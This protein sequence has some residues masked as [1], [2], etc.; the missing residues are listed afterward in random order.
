MTTR[1]KDST[2]YPIVFLMVDSADHQTG[3]TGLTP[4]LTASKN[5]GAF[6]AVSGA[7]SELSSGWYSWAGHATDRNTLGPLAIHVTGTGADVVDFTVDITTQDAFAAAGGGATAQQVWEYATRALTDKAGFSL[8]VA[9]PTAS[10]IATAVWGATTRTL[11]SFG[12]LISDIWANATRSLTEKTGFSLA[13]PPPTASDIATAV[14][15]AGTR[16]LT[17]FG[18]LVADIW[19]YVTRTITSGGITAQQVW[20]YATRALTDKAGF[21]L[22]GDYDAAKTAASAANLATVDT[23]ADAIKEKTDSLTFTTPNKVDA[24]ATVST[25]GIATSAEVAAVNAN[26]LALTGTT[27]S[28]TSTPPAATQLADADVPRD[29]WISYAVT[30]TPLGHVTGDLYRL[31]VRPF[32][33]L[34]TANVNQTITPAGEVFTLAFQMPASIGKYYVGVERK[35]VSGLTTQYTT[36]FWA[37]WSAIDDPVHPTHWA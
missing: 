4:T 15:A 25:A 13:T 17:S 3:K 6:G 9:P 2:A 12:T 23:V 36:L 5:G 1:L 33:A 7:V 27:V 8:S 20:E 22:H 28:Q 32:S 35:R 34:E 21:A 10:D 19:S 30:V 16:T 14:W 18:T 11:S 37:V 31:V 29:S 24:T 26:V